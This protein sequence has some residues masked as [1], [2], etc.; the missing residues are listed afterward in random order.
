MAD[1]TRVTRLRTGLASA[2][3]LCTLLAGVPAAARAADIV[4]Q[5]DGSAD[6]ARIRAAAGVTLERRLALPG[7]E[8]VS[9]PAGR[10]TRALAALN[11][12]PR[13]RTAA[14][15]VPVHAAAD[16]YYYTQWSLE[17]GG[18]YSFVQNPGPH[19]DA[20]IDA[21][22]AWDSGTDGTGVTVAVVDTAVDQTN[23]D[24]IDR[25]DTSVVVPDY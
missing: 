3:L 15:D 16:A 4:V 13:V 7:T 12:D 8:V 21:Q 9:V 19:A 11:A 20:D 22:D 2:L 23:T 10:E 14:P 17:N 6:A 1:H 18:A 5:R 25:I 24:L